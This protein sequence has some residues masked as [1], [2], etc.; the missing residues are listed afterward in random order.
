MNLVYSLLSKNQNLY[1]RFGCLR[2]TEANRKIFKGLDKLAIN[3]KDLDNLDK[4]DFSLIDLETGEQKQLHETKI[5]VTKFSNT[6]IQ[7]R[8]E[9]YTLYKFKNEQELH[10]SGGEQM[11]EASIAL[12]KTIKKVKLE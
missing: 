12:S 10:Y 3:Y 11:K 4:T 9:D 7:E 2:N 5:I 1:N 6:E 8:T